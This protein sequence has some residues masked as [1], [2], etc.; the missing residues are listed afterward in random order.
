MNRIGDACW[1]L[2]NGEAR[3]GR[4]RMWGQDTEEQESGPVTYPVA[5][6]EDDTTRC[7]VVV[8]VTDVCF[9][10]IPPWPVERRVVTE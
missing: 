1:Y 8:H 2:F 3:G 9:A 6:V 7:P 5:V 10:S 4:L